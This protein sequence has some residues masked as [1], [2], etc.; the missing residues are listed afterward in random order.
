MLKNE[1]VQQKYFM[2]VGKY[3]KDVKQVA[4]I[5]TELELTKLLKK[6]H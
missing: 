3:V 5:K 6:W 1:E 4:W 2:Y